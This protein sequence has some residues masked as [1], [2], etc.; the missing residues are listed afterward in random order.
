MWQHAAV[1]SRVDISGDAIAGEKASRRRHKF[2][3]EVL[4]E[5]AWKELHLFGNEGGV[6]IGRVVDGGFDAVPIEGFVVPDGVEE[7]GLASGGCR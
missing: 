1:E 4:A 2:A 3:V 6:G 7:A 5:R